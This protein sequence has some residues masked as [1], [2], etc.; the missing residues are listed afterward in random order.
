MTDW[1]QVK[2]V[3]VIINH[4]EKTAAKA[5]ANAKY[6]KENYF[7]EPPKAEPLALWSD[8]KT[9]KDANRKQLIVDLHTNAKV[10]ND[11]TFIHLEDLRA[12]VT[13]LKALSCTK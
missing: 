3:Q 13:R 7:F 12:A 1:N 8:A 4:I 5:A 6:L 10:T 2:D 11:F 9:E